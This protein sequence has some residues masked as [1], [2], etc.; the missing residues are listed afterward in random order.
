MEALE[1]LAPNPLAN[2]VFDAQNN[3]GDIIR[4]GYGGKFKQ[5]EN[6]YEKKRYQGG[7][8]NQQTSYPP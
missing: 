1:L 4:A 6:L 2:R 5:V 3:D 7:Q 8:K